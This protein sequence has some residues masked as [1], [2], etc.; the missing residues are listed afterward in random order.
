MS[1]NTTPNEF[2]SALRLGAETSGKPTLQVD[3]EKYEQLLEDADLTETQKR[4]FI[5][6]LWSIIV[7]FASLGFGVQPMQQIDQGNDCNDSMIAS[8]TSRDELK[9]DLPEDLQAML[10]LADPK[11]Q[12]EA[13]DAEDATSLTQRESE[14]E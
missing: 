11:K 9:Y 4:E 12:K 13:S 3:Y 5:T 10:E 1:K 7:E 8:E 14:A 6:A 2:C